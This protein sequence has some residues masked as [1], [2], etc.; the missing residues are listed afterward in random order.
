MKT[1]KKQLEAII[2]ESVKKTLEG[3]DFGDRDWL[4]SRQDDNAVRQT[5]MKQP[6]AGS[7]AFGQL[8]QAANAAFRKIQA[9]GDQAKTNA[10]LPLKR[11]V[12]QLAQ[13]PQSGANI[14]RARM[15]TGKLVALSK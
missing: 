5:V 4:R 15:L 2:R 3:L 7:P 8:V 13:A 9:K 6:N 11:E 10:A 12:E 1:T 14:M